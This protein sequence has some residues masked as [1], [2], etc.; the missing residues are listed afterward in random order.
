MLG[1]YT[2]F[3]AWEFCGR[4]DDGYF[5]LAPVALGLVGP[6]FAGPKAL[7]LGT[8]GQ[9]VNRYALADYAPRLLGGVL[10]WPSAL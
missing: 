7:L 10:L 3:P 1:T 9:R 5:G 6:P 8:P 2:Q 4:M